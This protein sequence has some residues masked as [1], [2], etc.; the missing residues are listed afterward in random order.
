MKTNRIQWWGVVV[1]SG[2]VAAVLW[3]GRHHPAG[4]AANPAPEPPGAAPRTPVAAP[5]ME[6][7]RDFTLYRHPEEAP[8]WAVPYGHEFWRQPAPAAAATA[9]TS[10]LRTDAALNLGAVIDRVSH[11]FTTANPAGRPGVQARTYTAA[12][13]GGGIKF[14]PSRPL[15]PAPA[16]TGA[17]TPPRG[18]TPEE[19]KLAALADRTPETPEEEDLLMAR[20]TALAAERA[21]DEANRNRG[22]QKKPGLRR[23]PAV[24][25]ERDPLTQAALR[26]AS[27]RQGS[28]AL[29][30]PGAAPLHW[31][32]VGNTAQA[33]LDSRSG[34]LEHF[35]AEDLGLAFTWVLPRPLTGSAPLV[36]EAQLTGLAYAGQTAGGH[37]YA[38]KSGTAR[39]RVG[40][41]TLADSRAGRWQ[42]PVEAKGETL[43][44]TVPSSVLGQA[45]YP[46][47]IDPLVS[48]EFGMD[49]PVVV[50]AAAAQQNPAVAANGAGFFV[51]W[52]DQRISGPGSASIFG[53]RVTGTGAISDPNG[54]S[55][56]P[57]GAS[58]PAVAANGNG[59]LVVWVDGR[60]AT[61]NGLDIFGARV[62]GAG[63][64][65]DAGGF[66]ISLGPNDQLYP[67]AVAN[68]S[69]SFVVWQDGRNP[70]TAPD[71]YGARVTSA[72][73]VL[74]PSG[75]A[76]STAVGPQASPA[77]A[78]NGSDFLAI[79]TD[80]RD[81]ADF[82]IYGAR[83]SPAG[84]VLD[85]S[86]IAL[87]TVPGGEFSPKVAASGDN[88]IGVWEDDRNAGTSFVDVYAARVAAS[89]TV[90]DPGGFLV[91]TGSADRHTP[92]VAAGP[93]DYLVVWQDSQNL[94][95]SGLDIYGARVTTAGTVTDPT[96]F[97]I[98][99][100]PGDQT[101]PVLAFNGT[102]YLVAWTDARNQATTDL[103]I[104]GTL[105][106]PDAVVSPTAGFVISTGSSGEQ[107]PATASNGTNYLVAWQDD[108]DSA[109]N[110]A[111]IYGVRVS[112][113]GAILDPA[114]IPISTAP[115][116]QTSPNVAS[117][118]TDYLVVWSDYRNSQAGVDVYG[119]R[120]T[121]AGVVE[122][123]AG[124]P[125]ST[126]SPNQTAP[127]VA[128]GGGVY[129]V[130][131]QDER[132]LATTG[133]DIYGARVSSAGAVLDVQ[134]I[135][136]CTVTGAQY[137]AAAAFNGTDFLVV[138][139]DERNLGVSGV[140]VYGTRVTTSGT[141]LDSS[142]L[143]MT[144]ATG[145]DVLPAVASAAGD[146]LVVWE[147]GRNAE[148]SGDNIYGTRVTGAGV[149]SDPAGL[150]ICTAAGFQSTPAVAASGTD[151]LVVW[152]DARNEATQG[153]DTY[154]A[155]VTTAGD[156]PDGTGLAINTGAS[157]QTFARVASASP[158]VFL[159]V[160]QSLE[161]GP[162]RTVGNLVYL[163][164]APVI[165]HIFLAGGIATLTW[166][167][168]PETLYQVQYE[169]GL[170][171]P[172][173]SN[174]SPETLASGSVSTQVD[175]TAGSV[176]VRFYR[177]TVVPPD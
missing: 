96:G 11:S 48:P 105:V 170:N 98:D 88:F 75:I 160:C 114:A 12:L 141:V 122:D 65:L 51:A 2:V 84:V 82:E 52:E 13:G 112:A 164:N 140:D 63:A 41:V 42:V 64:V 149:V 31:A 155:R 54:I 131:W 162:P 23:P 7:A 165:T 154:G 53:T 139:A 108:R 115:E 35:E 37:H 119:A 132:N 106:T 169:G 95:T 8:A 85:P 135:P 70:A 124:I 125:I 18:L 152:Q 173:W 176:P 25:P 156:L 20:L 27:A 123:P 45:V 151:Y 172:M 83:V 166:L 148:T 103:D 73:V 61:T 120:V 46:L 72:G 81:G 109:T 33:V 74:D 94:A 16:G 86:G 146:F 161:S 76:I 142:N 92:A 157:D 137:S 29:Y 34:L 101:T 6:T 55:I 113:G 62:N 28:R 57:V 32:V 15:N 171:P 90:L 87:S 89:G 104:Y 69:D 30:G 26:T 38:D 79:W 118:G 102:Q 175:A 168:V 97:A 40:N 116:D 99:T 9:K 126:A 47:A 21:A 5:G 67:A 100:A 91:A 93:T 136:I 3:R 128:G 174:L 49:L 78:F 163:Q 145:D 14:S 17:G 71:I 44:I 110:G 158:D 144:Q 177:V 147:D 66:A 143:P 19:Q 58:S 130:T 24:L 36:I 138:W 4:S 133:S 60:N 153:L 150:A 107:Q 1:I 167:S 129:L 56:S 111:D 117:D 50:P 127:A 134:G 22:A 68:G 43:R 80:E 39:L 77:V 121:S 59:Y 10:L 159:V